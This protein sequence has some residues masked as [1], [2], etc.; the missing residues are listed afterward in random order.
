MA[1]EQ[2]SGVVGVGST[3]RIR[4]VDKSGQPVKYR[5][6]PGV[7]GATSA[8]QAVTIVAPGCGGL[9]KLTPRSPLAQVLLGHRVGDVVE[10]N[11]HGGL[12]LWFELVSIQDGSEVDESATS[13]FGLPCDSAVPEA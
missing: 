10:L 8:E 11:G 13:R 5:R 1:S 4:T 3:V 6:F 12:T 2:D 7:S 9:Y